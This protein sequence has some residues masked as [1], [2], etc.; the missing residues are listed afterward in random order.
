MQY[1]QL[2]RMMVSPCPT[3]WEAWIRGSVP[4][5][6][7]VGS[8]CASMKIWVIMEVVVVLPWVPEMQMAF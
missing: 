7:T 5:I 2:S 8:R 1:S 4:P 3:R 6:I